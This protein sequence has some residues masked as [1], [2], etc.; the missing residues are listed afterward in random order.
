[1]G[2]HADFDRI[3]GEFISHFGKAQGELE[4][5]SWI[6][7]IGADETKPYGHC[8]ESFKWAKELIEKVKEDE[9][10]EYFKVWPAFPLKSMNGNVYTRDMLEKA[11]KSLVGKVPTMQHKDKYRLDGA[12]YVA[13][14][15]E[16]DAVETLLKI[17]KKLECPIPKWNK[18]VCKMIH[19]KDIV[20]VSLEMQNG[21]FDTVTLLVKDTLPGIPLARIRPLEAIMREAFEMVEMKKTG[22]RIKV[23]GAEIDGLQ[24]PDP[25]PPVATQVAVGNGAPDNSGV[26]VLTLSKNGK[27]TEMSEDKLR[28]YIDSLQ[29]KID[30][31]W[32]D[33]KPAAKEPNPVT[34]MYVELEAAKSALQDI[35]KANLLTQEGW[36]DASFPDSSFAYVPDKAKGKDGDKSLRKLPYKDKDGTVDMPH[37]RNALARLNQT[38]DVPADEKDAIRKMLQGQM[39]KANPDYDPDKESLEAMKIGEIEEKCKGLLQRVNTMRS[40][41]DWAKPDPGKVAELDLLN[42]AC[43]AYRQAYLTALNKE[44]NEAKK[45]ELKVSELNVAKVK[46]ESVGKTQTEQIASLEQL[47]AQGAQAL[48]DARAEIKAVTSDR[49]AVLGREKEHMQTIAAKDAK[50]NEAKAETSRVRSEIEGRLEEANAGAVK[51]AESRDGFKKQLEDLRAEHEKTAK[52]YN[53]VLGKN[54]DLTRDLTKANEDLVSVTKEKELFEAKIK[55]MVHH[56]KVIV[57]T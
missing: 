37:V 19:D 4:Y 57:N 30:K 56:A 50:I 21:E 22:V 40:E 14:Q 29:A 41:I 10:N 3:H 7:D 25:A 15:I 18:T 39:K 45:L 28:A 32:A 35:I 34:A 27:I 33:Q 16:D 6:K 8:L 43:D 36:G 48:T 42:M 9:D 11:V 46:L 52:N 31:Y 53:E 12:K 47:I 20:N 54:V 24:V 5:R 51:I 23:E 55:N 2:R 1:M 44:I 38:Q 26:P 49:D 13:A 17:P